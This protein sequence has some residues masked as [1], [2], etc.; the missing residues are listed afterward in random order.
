M[1]RVS[2]ALLSS[3]V[4]PCVI[5]QILSNGTRMFEAQRSICSDVSRFLPLSLAFADLKDLQNS[6]LKSHGP[7]LHPSRLSRR[8]SSLR[9][10]T[11]E[12][13]PSI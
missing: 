2:V 10:P 5:L 7:I 11:S 9:R 6:F 8:P 1:R 12:W 13:L 4:D 3:I